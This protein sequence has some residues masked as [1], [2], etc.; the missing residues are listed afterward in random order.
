MEDKRIICFWWF[1]DKKIIYN[2]DKIQKVII[3]KNKSDHTNDFRSIENQ[4][5]EVSSLLKYNISVTVNWL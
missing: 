5:V 2:P 4:S 3:D 1:C